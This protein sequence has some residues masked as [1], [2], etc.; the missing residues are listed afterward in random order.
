MEGIDWILLICVCK[1]LFLFLFLKAEVLIEKFFL[2]L[3]FWFACCTS[4]RALNVVVDWQGGGRCSSS[5]T[6]RR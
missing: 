2:P 4:C 5:E 1:I 6:R 3:V